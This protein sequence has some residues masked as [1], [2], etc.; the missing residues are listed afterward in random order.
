MFHMK[1][2]RNR[3][4]VYSGLVGAKM[5]KLPRTTPLRC[6][7]KSRFACIGGPLN[8]ARL[9]IERDSGPAHTLTFTLHGQT[10]R[11]FE[12]RWAPCCDFI[13]AA[14]NGLDHPPTAYGPGP[15]VTTEETL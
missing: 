4:V 6:V 12:W 9:L 3:G 7:R 1:R 10:G 8:S 2:T 15:I 5:R 11:Y 13:P 14:G